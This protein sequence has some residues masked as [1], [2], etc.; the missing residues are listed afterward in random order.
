MKNNFT[1]YILLFV[2]VFSSWNSQATVAVVEPFTSHMVLQRNMKV[3]VWG[4]GASGEKV[5]VKFNGQQKSVTTGADRKWKL[6]LDPMVAGGP[7]TMTISGTN[8]VSLTDVYVGEVWQ[9]G[10][11][12]NMD[13]TL[14]ATDWKGAFEDDIASA[15]FPRMRYMKTRK[16]NRT[17]NIVSPSTAAGLS[18]TGFFFG[19]ELLQNVDCA[20][21]LMVTAVGG[22]MIEQWFDPESMKQFKGK[23]DASITGGDMYNQ[24]VTPVLG[25]GIRGT[26]WIQGEQNASKVFGT[27]DYDDRFLAVITNWRKAWGQGEFP[28]YFGQITGTGTTQTTPFPNSPPAL[29]REGQRQ[30][31]KLPQTAMS[32]MLDISGGGWHYANKPEAGRRLAL[33][34]KALLYGKT[35]EY[36]GPLFESFTVSG[37]NVTVKFS[38]SKGLK[39]ND[40]K[41]PAGFALAGSDGK[42][43]F[44]DKASIVGSNIVLSSINVPKPIQVCFGWN[45]R[46]R[47]NVYNSDNLQ[48]SPFLSDKLGVL[49]DLEELEESPTSYESIVY[50]NPAIG[51]TLYFAS[52]ANTP[53]LKVTISDLMGKTLLEK[54][55]E[56]SELDISVLP[57]GSYVFTIKTDHKTSTVKLIKQ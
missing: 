56:S 52:G 39:T 35:V 20:V 6:Q 55:V 9:V 32:V 26:V 45:D 25:Y 1:F 14:S 34:P 7:Y 50:P 53:A 29:V 27:S 41:P 5:T 37:S 31:L 49:T 2:S 40:G 36:M 18:A 51:N 54:N 22:T 8:T 46:P 33:A 19:K 16:G 11:Q 23:I 30:A 28:F 3:N 12:S 44:A 47:L 13:L 4:T 21:G 10:G 42:W 38:H 15:N 57:S 48:A 24:F 17:W 43:Y